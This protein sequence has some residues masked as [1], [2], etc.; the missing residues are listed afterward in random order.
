MKG[1]ND[2]KFGLAFNRIMSGDRS[3]PGRREWEIA[4]V[5]VRRDRHS[6]SGQGYSFATE[7][8]TL[9]SLGRT[10]WELLIVKEYWWDAQHVAVRSSQWG[11]LLSGSKSA[12]LDWFRVR[13]AELETTSSN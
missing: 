11:K 10:K 12:A 4:G 1:F 6:Y 2:T 8:Y 5:Q 3:E 13:S 9:T 7:A